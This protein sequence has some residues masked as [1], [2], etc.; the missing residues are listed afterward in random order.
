LSSHIA[1]WAN[2]DKMSRELVN[3]LHL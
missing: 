3:S 1:K 2:I